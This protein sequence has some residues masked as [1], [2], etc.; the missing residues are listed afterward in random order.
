V[1]IRS[2]DDVTILLK[3]DQKIIESGKRDYDDP[4]CELCKFHGGTK[5]K[6][7]FVTSSS[8]Y[9]KLDPKAKTSIIVKEPFSTKEY[10][11]DL[12]LIK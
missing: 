9:N 5:A 6:H 8:L 1:T 3:Q 10:N 4:C 2:T 12:F 7:E 11:V